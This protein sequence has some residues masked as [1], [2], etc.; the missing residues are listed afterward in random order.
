MLFLI[1]VGIFMAVMLLYAFWPRRRRVVDGD[2]HRS[3]GDEGGG[4]GGL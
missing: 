4:G 2:V 3:Q 1:I